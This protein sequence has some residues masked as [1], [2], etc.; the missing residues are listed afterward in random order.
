M[1][2]C[3]LSTDRFIACTSVGTVILSIGIN[4]IPFYLSLYVVKRVS[5]KIVSLLRFWTVM[6]TESI[7]SS[8][9]Y[10]KML[11][12]LNKISITHL[13]VFHATRKKRKNTT[14]SDSVV[15][16]VSM[17]ADW[18][19]KQ[20]M[21]LLNIYNYCFQSVVNSCHNNIGS[22]NITWYVGIQICI[23]YVM[24]VKYN[25]INSY[26][27]IN[28]WNEDLIK[29]CSSSLIVYRILKTNSLGIWLEI[30]SMLWPAGSI[31]YLYQMM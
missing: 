15:V 29:V 27:N 28:I 13:L 23:N 12:T 17:N 5:V 22:D 7:L 4:F 3:I 24:K 31:T 18:T 14:S 21:C 26:G 11:Q 30:Y 2:A 10:R 19:N 16:P 20:N 1:T 9:W 25:S 8:Y 6:Y